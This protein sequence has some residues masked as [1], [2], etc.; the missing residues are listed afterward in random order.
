[1]C[2]ASLNCFAQPAP[3]SSPS[4]PANETTPAA[5]PHFDIFEYVVDGNTVLSVPDIETAVYPYLGE[6]RTAA[7]VD[8]ARDALQRSYED[9]G[10]QTV[11]VEIPQQGVESGTIHFQV[12]ENPV[13][14]LRVVDAR[15]HSLE[16]IKQHALSVAEGTV[17]NMRA[18]EQ[19]I[20]ALNSQ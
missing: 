4:M 12:V 15:Y 1:L 18:L 11:Q 13:G 3:T 17:P 14:R 7:D 20:V 8:K 6:S 5:Q 19:D 2:S 16:R 9:R 10:Y